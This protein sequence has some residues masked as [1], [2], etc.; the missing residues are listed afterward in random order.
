MD[1]VTSRQGSDGKPYWTKIGSAW[2]TKSGGWSLS[3]DALPIAS[4]N[5]QGK[6]ETR[7]LLMVPRDNTAARGNT[8]ERSGGNGRRWEPAGPDEGDGDNAPFA[9]NDP[10]AR[11]PGTSKRRV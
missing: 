8:P 5:D 9:T 3:F 2:E 10:T 11:E 4:M 6:L 7:A 1:I